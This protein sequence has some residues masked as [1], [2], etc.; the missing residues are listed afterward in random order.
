MSQS[1]EHDY[2]FRRDDVGLHNWRERPFNTW[3]FRHIPE[4]IP[5]AEIPAAGGLVEEAKVDEAWLASNEISVADRRMTIS[6]VLAETFTDALVVMKRG[7]IAAEFHAPNFTTRSRHILFS[8]SKSV[9]GIL[10]GILV[11]DGLLDPDEMISKYV[12]ELTNSAFGDAKVR[13]ALDMRTSLS[14]TEDYGDPRGDFARYRRAG[15]LDP[16]LPGEP[17]ETVISF[18]ASLKKAPRDHGGPFFYGSPNSDVVG[19][20]VERAAGMR[21]PDLMAE[22]LWQP[23][24]ARSDARITVDRQGTARAGG[25]IFMT[26]RDFA[27]FGDLVRCDGTV[28]GRQIVPSEWVRNTTTGGDR[29]AWIDGNFAGWLPAGSYRNQWYQS[30]NADG[31]FFALGIHGQWLWIN[32]RRELVIAKF[33]SQPNPV[34]DAMKHMNMALFSAIAE[35]M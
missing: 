10:A 2:G 33:S 1:F 35:L 27:R 9:T 13:H 7:R 14:F 22:K 18:L 29:Q 8:A 24:A 32:P 17:V 15:L 12:P 11:A 6:D 28:D 31:A 23:L 34:M 25:G 26:V 4:L 20:V 5:T 16:A 30:G 21:F 19:L 3:G